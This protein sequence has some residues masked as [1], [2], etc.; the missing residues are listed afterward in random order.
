MSM[1]QRKSNY[2][3]SKPYPYLPPKKVYS[4]VPA[5]HPF[6]KAAKKM[7]SRVR[8][9]FPGIAAT[10]SIVARKD[11]IIGEGKNKPIHLSFCPRTA[12]E[13]PSGEGYELCP[14]YCHS[15]NHSEV[16]VI[17]DAK[18]RGE[19]TRGANLY[20]YGHWWCCKPCWDVIME[21]GIKNVYLVEG[22]TE[23]FFSLVSR[24]GELPKPLSYYAAS[25]ITQIEH[26]NLKRFHQEV[27]NLLGRVNVHAY[28]PWLHTDPVKFPHFTPR[29]VYVR[30]AERIQ[31][32]D[33]VLAYLGEPS[34]GVGVEIELARQHNVPVIG[35]ASTGAKISRMALGAPSLK[36]FFF[37]NDI[38]NFIVKLSEVLEDIFILK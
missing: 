9:H 27:A 3:S 4:Y 10:S 17:R 31:Q 22:A 5:T 37:F 26:D 32:S 11:K 23:K 16:Q 6:M 34:L 28:L 36:S 35:F 33:F 2:Q 7:T 12:F 25:A 20:L 13:C 30:N 29:E 38:K 24:K 18:E 1:V 21:A 19:N 14:R 8:K 15:D